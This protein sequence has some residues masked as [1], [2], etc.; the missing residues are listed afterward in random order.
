MFNKLLKLTTKV[1]E[2]ISRNTK[3]LCYKTFQFR[4]EMD[5]FR[6]KLVSSGLDKHTSL[7]KQAH[8]LTTEPVHY[9]SPMFIYYKPQICVDHEYNFKLDRFTKIQLFRLSDSI[10]NTSFSS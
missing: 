5:R 3:A 4:Q 2:A 10:H 7:R 6:S 1:V 9:E 8:Y